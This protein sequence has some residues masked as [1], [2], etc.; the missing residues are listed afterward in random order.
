MKIKCAAIYCIVLDQLFLCRP[1]YRDHYFSCTLACAPR[2]AL[3][4]LLR[5]RELIREHAESFFGLELELAYETTATACWVTGAEL[6]THVDNSKAYLNNRDISAVVWLNDSSQYSGGTFFY[7]DGSQLLDSDDGDSCGSNDNNRRSKRRRC[8]IQPKRGMGAF[9]RSELRHGVHKVE[10]GRRLGLLLWFTRSG[11]ADVSEDSKIL[12]RG[13]MPFALSTPEERL[14]GFG[15]Q[16]HFPQERMAE[17][18][19]VTAQHLN[20]FFEK[21]HLNSTTGTFASATVDGCRHGGRLLTRFSNVFPVCPQRSVLLLHAFE[22]FCNRSDSLPGAADDASSS[23]LFCNDD[24]IADAVVDCFLEY[25]SQRTHDVLR[26]EVNWRSSGSL[27]FDYAN[28]IWRPPSVPPRSS[29]AAIFTTGFDSL[30][31]RQISYSSVLPATRCSSSGDDSS[32]SIIGPPGLSYCALLTPEQ[33]AHFLRAAKCDLSP[34]SNQAMRFGHE[35]FPPWAQELAKIV[36]ASECLPKHIAC[37]NDTGRQQQPKQD[38]DGEKETI[39]ANFNQLILNQ[40]QAGGDGICKHI[41]LLRFQD[42]ICGVS[43]GSECTMTF[44]QLAG[45]KVI[46]SGKEC[47]WRDDGE[48]EE[49]DFTGRTFDI[50]LQPGMLYCLSGDARYRWTHEIAGSSILSERINVTFRRM[51][52][53]NLGLEQS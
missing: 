52:Q 42:G 41:D 45:D 24:H 4:A 48:V 3:P 46:Q 13:F 21:T 10:A 30:F 11:G 9:F 12:Q 29:D 19:D 31:G 25:F 33:Q 8:E 2:W 44:R 50:V 18:F 23:L 47:V 53:A 20:T 28:H 43:L 49:Q 1:G 15:P 40:Y 37:E 39:F 17:S 14:F 27:V 6:P 36:L 32:K 38:A 5:A 7:E 26:M 34:G 51:E 16:L 35:H 22:Q